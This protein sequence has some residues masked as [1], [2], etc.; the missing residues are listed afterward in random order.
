MTRIHGRKG[1][2]G[3][4]NAGYAE[5]EKASWLNVG[6]REL[7]MRLSVTSARRLEEERCI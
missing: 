1:G 2:V 7:C 6:K 3:G 4:G 5:G